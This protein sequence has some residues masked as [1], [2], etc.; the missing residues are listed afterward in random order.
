MPRGTLER[1]VAQGYEVLEVEKGTWTEA[2]FAKKKEPVVKLRC[3]SDQKYDE[4]GNLIS[5]NE[6]E[7]IDDERLDD[8]DE[9][10]DNDD[11]FYS[12]YAAEAEVKEETEE[13]FPIEE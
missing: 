13:G 3:N 12:S 8:A 11:T 4:E 5:D 10:M 1:K 6:D 7:D 2:I 9:D